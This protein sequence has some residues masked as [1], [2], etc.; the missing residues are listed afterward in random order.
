[1]AVA[2]GSQ[3]GALALAVAGLRDDLAGAAVDVPFLCDVRRASE[4]SPTAPYTELAGYLAVHPGHVDRVFATL[5]H[6]DGAVLAATATAPALFSVGLVDEVCPPSTV[7][8]AFNAYGGPK[9]IREYP[10]NGHEGGG[11]DHEAL[12]LDRLREWLLG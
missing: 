1:M 3:G 8:A 4:V 7:Y 9:E 5:A 11:A 2:G 10:Y 6:V 12:V